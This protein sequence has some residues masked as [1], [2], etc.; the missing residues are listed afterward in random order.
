[1]DIGKAR[2][3][4]DGVTA[5]WAE[6]GGPGGAVVLFDAAHVLHASAGGFAELGFRT[7][8]TPDTVG[9]WASITKHIFC[10][11]LLRDGRMEMGSTLGAWLPDLQP[12]LAGV[13]LEDA[14]GMTGG[15][16]DLMEAGWLAGV[17]PTAGAT[18]PG[19]VALAH[20][21]TALNFS[22]GTEVAYTNTG[23]LLAEAGLA[24]LGTGF[25]EALDRHF[26]APLDLAMHY[27]AD[28]G[29]VLP[30]LAHGYWR[31][32]GGP[33]R[34]GTYGI[35]FAASGGIAGSALT[36]AAWSQALL[37]DAGPTQGLLDWL[38]TP[39]TLP[40]G[41]PADYGRGMAIHR[42][43]GV[44]LLGHGG[45]LP[46]MKNHFLLH[47]PSG[48]GVV[49]LSNREDT[50][51]YG[52]ALRVM[53]AG[54]DATHP[55]PATS[56]LPEGLFADVTGAPCWIE[57]AGSLVT[58]MGAQVPLYRAADGA[59]FSLSPYIAMALQADGDDI[60]G[61]VGHAPRRFAKVGPVALDPHWAGRWVLPGQDAV[62][63]IAARPGGATITQGLGPLA[64]TFPLTALDADRATFTRTDAQWTQRP[65]LAFSEDRLTLGTNR[66]RGLVFVRA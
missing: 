58:F 55:E 4:A 37:R 17:P 7:P 44:T 9:R 43:G 35:P 60:A 45:S 62:L 21:L 59:A 61:H 18:I 34:I 54:L 26:L 50:D 14:L 25:A 52:L 41:A 28:Y 22:T 47:R 24:R 56:L 13:T 15:L 57:V 63:T 42:V 1:M 46:G 36:L 12:A 29:V 51:A 6:Q 33:W 66:C 65:C 8:F 27:P 19:M 2:Q 20:R 31:R 64:A 16:P 48:T 38:A 10:A 32:D 5:D 30:A 3:A 39:R 49:V 11:T 53:L 40:S 23:Y